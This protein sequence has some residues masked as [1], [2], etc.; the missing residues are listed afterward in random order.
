MATV[1][2]RARVAGKDA[3]VAPT[4][5]LLIPAH[6]REA[7][8]GIVDVLKAYYRWADMPGNFQGDAKRLLEYSDRD[9][10]SDEYIGFIKTMFLRMFPDKT[11]A[12]MQ[13]LLSFAK[14][15]YSKRGTFNSYKFLFR[16]LYDEDVELYFPSEFLMK[17]SNGE[18]TTRNIL[19][20]LGTDPNIKDIVGRRIWGLNSG[21]S[22]IVKS[23]IFY[24]A[25]TD[26]IS[27][28]VIVNED[29][30]FQ[31]NEILITKDDKPQAK[32]RIFGQIGS[33]TISNPGKGYLQGA[34]IPVSDHKSG[35][36]FI[37][38]I[39]AVD[40]VGAIL[41]IEILTSG[42]GYEE[43][44]HPVI[45]MAYSGLFD[46]DLVAYTNAVV[47]FSASAQYTTPG[48]YTTLKSA[49]SN[50]FKLQ[51][52]SY[53]QEFSYV[54]KTN[55]PLTKFESPVTSLVHPAGSTM[56]AQPDISIDL[57]MATNNIGSM[58]YQY[59][60]PAGV[61]FNNP[62]SN[63]GR[64]Y[65][66]IIINT[67]NPVVSYVHGTQNYT[68]ITL[69]V[70]SG[71]DRTTDLNFEKGWYTIFID[72]QLEVVPVTFKNYDVISWDNTYGAYK[73]INVSYI[74]LDIGSVISTQDITT[75]LFYTISY[76]NIYSYNQFI[77]LSTYD[78]LFL[79]RMS[80]QTAIVNSTSFTVDTE[81]TVNLED[82]IV[83]STGYG[84]FI[85][86]LL[87]NLMSSTFELNLELSR[88]SSATID[89]VGHMEFEDLVPFANYYGLSTIAYDSRI[90]LLP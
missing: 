1:K 58:L 55:V 16:A 56:F 67:K 70:S 76:D 24:A 83:A 44:E 25:D 79:N 22:A 89:E 46:P 30:Q 32:S 15:F 86:E 20:C 62:E 75:E 49:V 8:S 52:G 14:D 31:V 36:G 29:G 12:S 88:K 39:G 60:K 63:S 2:A 51:D 33:Y 26:V 35:S 18:W 6:I 64:K 80:T 72:K 54:L 45:N 42:I 4:S 3:N 84:I 21:A 41:T 77:K 5:A 65:F 68:R 85:V 50:S 9:L 57:S 37:A 53:F 69:H 47:Q 7:S 13:H 82:P 38:K 61:N 23:V 40:D 10:T 90:Q 87:Q 28:F 66:D 43:G 73:N 74:G 17:S 48:E 71:A 81:T 78:E 59:S 34:V 27:E 19:K 11:E